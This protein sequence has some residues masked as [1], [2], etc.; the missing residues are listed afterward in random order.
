M[1]AVFARAMALLTDTY[2]AH[3]DL[4]AALSVFALWLAMQ[5]G[6][7]W[8]SVVT[9]GVIALLL[10]NV[11]VTGDNADDDAGAADVGIDN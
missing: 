9:R 5:Y 1:G 3:A 2:R 4:L 8:V 6:P 11:V 10:I 7:R